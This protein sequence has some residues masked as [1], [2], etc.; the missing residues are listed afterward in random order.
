MTES[1]T[2]IASERE[3]KREDEFR[4]IADYGLLAVQ[5][6]YLPGTLVI[7]TTF[8]TD[9]GSVRLLDAM[10]FA[11]GQR[12]HDLGFDAPHELLRA[13][14][15]ISGRVELEMELAPR[16]EY[17]LVQ[18]LFRWE[19]RGGRT[20]GGPNRVTIRAGAPI[21]INDAT[22]RAS[23]EVGEDETTGFSMR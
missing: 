8:T 20:F 11:E 9:T 12:G 15:G 23:F 7:E 18:P 10:A 5:R 17:G 6:R 16:G 21:E 22:M 14:E 3:R 4:P 1:A 13:V 2:A 19:D